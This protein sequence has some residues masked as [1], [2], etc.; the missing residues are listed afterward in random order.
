MLSPAL[1]GLLLVGL[2]HVEIAAPGGKPLGDVPDLRLVAK[3]RVA[4]TTR[5]T[6]VPIPVAGGKGD[7]NLPPGDWT[8]SLS[9]P[10]YWSQDLQVRV[11]GKPQAL[12]MVLWHAGTIRGKIAPNGEIPSATKLALAFESSSKDQVSRVSS[13]TECPISDGQWACAVPATILDVQLK[14]ADSIPGYFWDVVVSTTH[15]VDLGPYRV[16]RGASV[17]GWAKY[18]DG[19]S[20][21]NVVVTVTS[22]QA[23]DQVPPGTAPGRESSARTNGRGFFQVVDVDGGERR[24]T[25]SAQ[26]FADTVVLARLR[27]DAET[28][29]AQPLV[30]EQP[31]VLSV[32]VTPPLDPDSEPWRISLYRHD[33]LQP[34]LKDQYIASSGDSAPLSI[35]RGLYRVEICSHDTNAV[36]YRKE[37]GVDSPT[38]LLD[39]ALPIMRVQGKVTLGKKPVAGSVIFGG[40]YGT[41]K[42]ALDT[43]AEGHFEGTVR[44]DHAPQW[45]IDVVSDSPLIRRTLRDVSVV[46]PGDGSPAEVNLKLPATSLYGV[47]MEE[48]GEPKPA[49]IVVTAYGLTRETADGVQTRAAPDGTF[50]FEGL[51]AGDFRVSAEARGATNTLHSDEISAHVAEDTTGPD[52]RLVL[53]QDS[54]FIGRLLSSEGEPIPDAAVLV[55]SADSPLAGGSRTRSDGDGYFFQDM[56]PGTR[57]VDLSISAMGFPFKMARVPMPEGDPVPITLSRDGG[58]V[59]LEFAPVTSSR[60]WEAIPFLFFGG[61]FQSAFFL[62]EWAGTHGGEWRV[63]Q[64]HLLIPA[65]APGNYTACV[66]SSL[67]QIEAATF[68]EFAGIPCVNGALRPNGVLTL[69]LPSAHKKTAASN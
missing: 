44:R 2:V 60:P 3:R 40:A 53:R 20:A 62:Q 10:G 11:S 24:V 29:V 58:S 37:V 15:P 55:S 45:D 21:A 33:P 54:R 69:R 65:M 1:L 42:I 26:G 68:G 34:V 41:V 59:D 47:V 17:V 35:P 61:S 39:V 6:S 12:S 16:R 8:V 4:D 30:L 38:H 32:H 56:A 49:A 46:D 25:A 43:D 31:A 23:P 7:A 18:S 57:A 9:A 14:V 64:G 22:S 51:P 66:T 36:W 67:V 48:E 28:L 19:S 27:T 50:Q 13:E 5:A 63:A 52:L